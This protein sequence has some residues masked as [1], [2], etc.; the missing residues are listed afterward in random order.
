MVRQRLS[1]QADAIAKAQARI[2]DQRFT[3]TYL[4]NHPIFS[5]RDPDAAEIT[6]SSEELDKLHAKIKSAMHT[7]ALINEALAGVK[8]VLAE[9]AEENPLTASIAGMADGQKGMIE[10]FCRLMIAK[11]QK[12]TDPAISFAEADRIAADRLASLEEEEQAA[13]QEDD[14]ELDLS[15]QAAVDRLLNAASAGDSKGEEEMSDEEALKR[16]QEFGL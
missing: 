12:E 14:D 4:K 16:M 15:D 13:G 8:E 10:T 9:D 1:E 11:E 6:V 3:L 7:A 5:R 2:V